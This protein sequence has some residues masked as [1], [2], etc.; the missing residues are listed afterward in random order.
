MLGA[1]HDRAHAAER[2]RQRGRG[3]RGRRRGARPRR[4]DLHRD[5]AG[6][7]GHDRADRHPPADRV[8]RSVRRAAAR[9]R[10]GSVP[11]HEALRGA[12]IQS[13][14]VGGR[15]RADL[16]EVH[17]P[18]ARSPA[19]PA[20]RGCRSGRSGPIRSSASSSSSGCREIERVARAEGVPVADG[21]DRADRRLRR[22]HSRD[23]ALVAADRSVAGEEDRGRGAAGSVVR[24]AARAGVPVPIMST[25]YAVLKPFA[26]GAPRSA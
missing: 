25:L 2:R 8:R 26:A 15:P 16:G 10:T 5:S 7:A 12:D 22:R 24:R 11:I 19:S 3:R 13:E 23:D 6:R 14:V 21:H 9:S 20:R 17:L 1:R 4:D 18:R